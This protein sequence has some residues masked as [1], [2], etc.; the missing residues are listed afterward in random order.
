MYFPSKFPSSKN[1]ETVQLGKVSNE[2]NGRILKKIMQ[3]IEMFIFQII[4]TGLVTCITNISEKISGTWC[5]SNNICAKR[6]LILR[7]F[8]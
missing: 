6:V 2:N 5:V 1:F 7:T 3:A 4:S 8:F